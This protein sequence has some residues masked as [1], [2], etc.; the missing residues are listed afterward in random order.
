MKRL[1]NIS[2]ERYPYMKRSLIGMVTYI[3]GLAALMTGAT[4]FESF[5]VMGVGAVL[6]LVGLAAIEE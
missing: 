6:M 1:I 4:I 2:T 5:F 3:V